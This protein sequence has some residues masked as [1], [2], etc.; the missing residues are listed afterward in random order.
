MKLKKRFTL[1]L[2][3][4]L[5]F[6][7]DRLYIGFYYYYKLGYWPNLDEPRL[8]NEKLQWVKLH[9][10]DPRLPDLVDKVKVRSYVEQR[11]GSSYLTHL[12]GVYDTVDDF[13]AADLPD[14]FVVKC[15]HD[16]QS[17]HVCVD[18]SL[19][20][21]K[22]AAHELGVAMH[23]NWYWQGREWAY[24][25]CV[26]KIIVEEYIQEP[27][28]LTPNDYK[29]YCFDGKVEIIQADMDRFTLNHKEQW[30][31][32][33]WQSLGDWDRYLVADEELIPRPFLLD[34]MI[35]LSE[36]LAADF[37]HVRVD[38][39]CIEDCLIFGELT[40]YTGGGFDPF[41]AKEDKRSDRL[42]IH[43]GNCF[44]LDGLRTSNE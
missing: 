14:Q 42:D 10:H 44:K 27:G 21:F 29:F 7:P 41:H 9:Y 22:S 13:L 23:R 8:F 40:F 37:P 2:K 36:K 28:K 19:F 43:L 30:F 34:Q 3:N 4:N 5:R 20:D 25:D 32:T 17:T 11:I 6:L 15:T 38:W 16:S 31:S 1:S 24:R 33:D 39:Y 18:K 26:P 35:D 12:Y